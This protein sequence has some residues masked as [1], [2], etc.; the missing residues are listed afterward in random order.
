MLSRGGRKRKFKKRNARPKIN[1]KIGNFL[2]SISHIQIKIE[3]SINTCRDR[4]W[5][6]YD[7]ERQNTVGQM[8]VVPC[9][10]V[11]CSVRFVFWRS[12]FCPSPDKYQRI[13]LGSAIHIR[14][15]WIWSHIGNTGELRGYQW[16]TLD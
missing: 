3:L 16:I 5:K 13:L 14:V 2:S 12:L 9:F 1:A 4:T 10:V 6:G 7:T 8:F 11:S 15:G